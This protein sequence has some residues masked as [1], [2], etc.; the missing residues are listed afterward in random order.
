M[1]KTGVGKK[2]IQISPLESLLICLPQ[3]QSVFQVGWSSFHVYSH[4]NKHIEHNFR[5]LE[6]DARLDINYSKCHVR[7]II[8]NNDST[9]QC[10]LIEIKSIVMGKKRTNWKEAMRILCIC[11]KRCVQ[12]ANMVIQYWLA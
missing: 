4:T 10:S 2:K 1:K 8:N 6:P 12:Y 5:H 11:E 3:I 7:F 9:M